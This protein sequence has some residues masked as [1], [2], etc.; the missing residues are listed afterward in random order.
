MSKSSSATTTQRSISSAPSNRRSFLG[1]LIAL[2]CLSVLPRGWLP[3]GSDA[4]TIIN[5]DGWVLSKDD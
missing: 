5:R 2:P 3:R 1:S 4:V